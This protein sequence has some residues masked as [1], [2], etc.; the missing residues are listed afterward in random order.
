MMQTG[1]IQSQQLTGQRAGKLESCNE[2]SSEGLVQEQLE[3]LGGLLSCS[4]MLRGLVINVSSKEHADAVW[5][6]LLC[7]CSSV[8]CSDEVSKAAQTMLLGKPWQA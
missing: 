1:W 4:I 3:G 2:S 5:T 6:W 7:R 8:C